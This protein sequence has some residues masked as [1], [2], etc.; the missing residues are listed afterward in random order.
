MFLHSNI[1]N[2][3][4]IV[5]ALI[6][7]IGIIGNLL[8]I[9]VFSDKTMRKTSTFRY[10]F[11]L[12]I[13]DLLVLLICGIDSLLEFD[14]LITI[15]FKSNLTCK[16]HTFLAYFLTHMS[17]FILMI[18]N[19][20]RVLAIKHYEN[21]KHRFVS[22]FTSK[23]N[24]VGKT[25][26]ILSLIL[27]ASNLHYLIFMKRN[28]M[29]KD[30]DR[31]II[32]SNYTFPIQTK[33]N[34]RLKESFESLTLVD[35]YYDKKDK[36]FNEI[37]SN[38]GSI[39]QR[40]SMLKYYKKFKFLFSGNASSKNNFTSFVCYPNDNTHY[41]FFI[42][43]IWIWIDMFLF[44]L[45]P[46]V[47]M[48]ICSF[49]ILIDIRTK[50]RNFLASKNKTISNIIQKSRQRNRQLLIMLTVTNVYFLFCS[51]PLCINIIIDKIRTNKNE[52]NLILSILQIIS[53]SNNSFNFMFYLIFCQN[54]RQ[55]IRSFFCQKSLN[56]QNS[57][58]NNQI[59]LVRI[60][61]SKKTRKRIVNNLDNSIDNQIEPNNSA[62]PVTL[63]P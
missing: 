5:L 33:L 17:S 6:I 52:T 13:I 36:R 31:K 22:F 57:T 41:Y 10:L 32:D 24:K 18:V 42:A 47:V 45:I 60:Y 30:I 48:A 29:E 8:N 46:F 20:N 21:V 50:S 35:Y 62:G 23:L 4:S 27:I 55:V 1:N 3:I 61:G 53:Y 56:Q 12:S 28:S 14:F 16:I 58:A 40:N 59:E 43:K 11:Y 19:I 37:M 38:F 15:K 25:I 9:I 26:L 51:L 44:S 49:I 34:K 2:L 63:L 7:L 54:Y 39:S